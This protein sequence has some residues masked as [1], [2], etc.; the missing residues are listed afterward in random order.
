MARVFFLR[1]SMLVFLCF[2]VASLFSATI[3]PAEEMTLRSYTRYVVQA[4]EVKESISPELR[5]RMGLASD[6]L[7]LTYRDTMN[8][9]SLLPKAAITGGL[10]FINFMQT[11][12]NL[13]RDQGYELNPLLGQHPSRRKLITSVLLSTATIYVLTSVLPKPLNGIFL[14]SVNTSLQLNIAWDQLMTDQ[15]IVRPAAMPLVLTIRF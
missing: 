1:H 7:R 10:S 12:Q 9:D 15:R 13:Y 4:S 11:Y 6:P 3:V 5:S 2:L 14:D 8:V